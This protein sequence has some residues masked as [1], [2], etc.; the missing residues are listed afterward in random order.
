[1]KIVFFGTSEFAIPSLRLLIAR[2]MAPIAA[3]TAPDKPKGRGQRLK[4][5]PIKQWLV[6]SD[7]CVGKAEKIQVFQPEKLDSDFVLRISNLKPD[8]GIVAA[9]GKILPK[10][11]IDLFP[12][13]VLNI[14]PS[15][16]P[17]YRG[18][19]P[20]QATILNGDKEAGV[21]IIQIDE[22]MDHGP[23]VA[24]Q[25]LEPSVP[26][27][28]KGVVHRGQGGEITSFFL[29]KTAYQE[30]HDILA[31]LGAQLLIET[32]PKWVA[33]EITLIPQNDAKTTY[34]KL[35]K[36]ED[37][38]IDWSKSAE[39]IERMVRAYNPWPGSYMQ[40]ASDQLLVASLKIK[41]AEVIIHPS[42]SPLHPGMFFKTAD[43]FPAIT[44]GNG[45][46]KLL[47]V[48]PEG[49]KEMSGDAFTHGYV[50]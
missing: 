7:Q 39:E 46:L 30:L 9:Y 16:L 29:K 34:T 25:Q 11:L 42:S 14:H 33:G 40:V 26:L 22:K 47:V 20:I 50:K 27:T 2:G 44:C 8:V 24:Q 13:G 10:E 48:Q 15:L 17:K 23:I 35:L 49:K 37:G 4:S 3:I 41:K 12:N 45:A 32:L 38:N 31:E 21:T 28:E 18:P 1:M 6:T 36:K 43:G 5:S 19:S